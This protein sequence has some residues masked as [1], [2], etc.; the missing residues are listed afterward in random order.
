MGNSIEWLYLNNSDDTVRY[1]LGEKSTNMIACIGINPSTA[2]P[3]ELDN[4]LKSVKRIS[5]FNGF[6]GWI[7]Y[8]VYPQRATDPNHL[9]NEIDQ[10]L[11]LTNIGVLVESIK[12]LGIN[13][14]WIAYGDL[15]ESREYL[16]FCMLSLYT[17]LSHLNLNWKIIGEPTQKGHPRHPLYKATESKFIDFEMEKYVTEKLKPK[18]KKFEKIYVNGIEFK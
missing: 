5:E 8:N 14:I 11:R 17:S 3:N 1:V 18:S 9:D 16:P 12:H 15:I 10:E 4:T 7:M 6:D 13:T 2:K